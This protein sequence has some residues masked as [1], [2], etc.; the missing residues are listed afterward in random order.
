[1]PSE[2]RPTLETLIWMHGL[3]DRPHS[4][5]EIFLNEEITPALE[6]TKIVLLHAPD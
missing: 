6:T 4:F 3:G 2:G 1:L 5:I